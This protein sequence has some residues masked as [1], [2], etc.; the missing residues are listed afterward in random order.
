MLQASACSSTQEMHQQAVKIRRS[1]GKSSPLVLHVPV[2]AAVEGSSD[3][4][5]FIG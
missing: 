2:Y 1:I 5:E 4:N 3:R